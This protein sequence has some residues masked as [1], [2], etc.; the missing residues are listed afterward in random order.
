MVAIYFINMADNTNILFHSPTDSLQF[1]LKPTALYSCVYHN[2]TCKT[3]P[4]QIMLLY[5]YTCKHNTESRNS[6]LHVVSSLL[7]VKRELCANE[8][9]TTESILKETGQETKNRQARQD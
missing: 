7:W 6:C 4:V 1:H 3:R 8:T 9:M 5:M 2:Y